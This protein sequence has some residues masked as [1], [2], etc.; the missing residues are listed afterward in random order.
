MS[1]N[2]IKPGDIG[3]INIQG[4]I[5]QFEVDRIDYQG[6]HAGNYIIVIKDSIY[7]V[8]DYN[9]PHSVS[10]VP[11]KR[12]VK[13]KNTVEGQNY[14]KL[15]SHPYFLKYY[16]LYSKGPNKCIVLEYI[17]DFVTFD[18]M[19]GYNPDNFL[20]MVKQSFTGLDY[21]HFRGVAHGDLGNGKNVL[22]TNDHV[23][24]IDFEDLIDVEPS[25][26]SFDNRDLSLLLW[27]ILDDD[28]P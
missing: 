17:E 10:F 12:F 1:N 2:D 22:W 8:K 13:C 28:V 27:L 19:F 23:I 16:G 15:G 9:V 20:E 24:L 11:V 5:Y 26:K 4:Q 25:I 7:Q 3:H 18:Q 21:M 14:E 6:I